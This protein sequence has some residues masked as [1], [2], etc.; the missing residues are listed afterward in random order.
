MYDQSYRHSDILDRGL[1]WSFELSRVLDN[2]DEATAAWCAI[3]ARNALKCIEEI[4][5]GLQA[6]YHP[7]RRRGRRRRGRRG[8]RRD[9]A[10]GTDN[11]RL[12]DQATL[13]AGKWKEPRRERERE[14]ESV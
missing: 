14:R 11:T 2:L 3:R 9:S 6:R 10:V 8:R 5:Y 4:T 1:R 13:F 12:E 7:R